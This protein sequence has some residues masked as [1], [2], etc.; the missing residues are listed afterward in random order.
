MAR[1]LV[2]DDDPISRQLLNAMLGQLGHEVEL[3]ADGEAAWARLMDDDSPEL[4]LL[5]WMMPGLSGLEVCQRV[6]L[7]QG[8]RPLYI[9]MLTSMEGEHNLVEALSVGADDFIPK[10]IHRP[11]L[12]ARLKVGLR[13][14]EMH[15]RLIQKASQLEDALRQVSAMSGLLAICSC[16]R[17]LRDDEHGW[18]YADEYLKRHTSLSFSHA[19]CPECLDG[20]YGDD[21]SGGGGC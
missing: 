4:V 11:V 5:D 20:R 10:P 18:S 3:A 7:I 17:R 12:V 13:N 1:L 9:I 19:L 2:V 21:G 6:R 14:L 16:C 15:H 8:T